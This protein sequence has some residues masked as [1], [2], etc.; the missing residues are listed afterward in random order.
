MVS[1]L[2]TATILPWGLDD[3][4]ITSIGYFKGFMLVFPPL[5]IVFD[6]FMIYLGFRLLLIVLK[7]F[8]GKRTPHHD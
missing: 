1:W 8:L 6:A 5:T 4:W 7:I 3:L 2:P